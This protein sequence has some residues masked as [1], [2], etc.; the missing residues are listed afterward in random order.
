MRKA[1]LIT[2]RKTILVTSIILF[3]LSIYLGIEQA[4]LNERRAEL[5]QEISLIEAENA[6]LQEQLSGLQERQNGVMQRMEDWLDAWEVDV[7]ESS[8]YAPLDPQAKEGMCFV[9]DPAITASGAKVIP[10]MT[11][12]AGA[13]VPFG[14][15]VRIRGAGFRKITD[16]GGRIRD[17]CIDL[18]VATREEALA[19][20]RK[21]V[22][23]VYRK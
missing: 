16:R 13:G 15:L 21:N 17:R 10:H 12:A 14:T 4:R 6:A 2:L 5:E 23:V 8:A 22:K 20:G 19:W 9:G 11:A 7:W 1:I 18:A 3:A